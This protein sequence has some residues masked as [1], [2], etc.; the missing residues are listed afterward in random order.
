M[1]PQSEIDLLLGCLRLEDTPQKSA[2]LAA[3]TPADW[4]AVLHQARLHGVLPLLD[5][6]VQRLDPPPPAVPPPVRQEMHQ[7]RLQ[8]AAR[9]MF[10][11]NELGQVLQILQQEAIPVI[12][13]KGLHLAELVYA[14]VALRKIDD[15]DLLIHLKDLQPARDSLIQAGYQP[16]RWVQIDEELRTH[17]HLPPFTSPR[18]TALELH[19]ALA[20]PSSRVN[21]NL[22]E[23]W[24]RAKIA[25]FSG[26]TAR[27]LCLEDLIL[28]LGLHF[29]QHDFHL[30]LR[31]LYDLAVI[32][33]YDVQWEILIER[34]QG[35]KAR[36]CTFL[37]LY[38]ASRILNA[39]VPNFVLEA[40]QPIDFTPQIAEL[41]QSRLLHKAFPPSVHPELAALWGDQP[42]RIRL[43][44]F[45]QVIFPLPEYIADRYNVPYGSRKIYFYY[46]VR[47]VSLLRQYS[48]TV[49][50]I[51]S[52]KPEISEAVRQETLLHD[53]RMKK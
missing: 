18:G 16:Y 44:A 14:D 48:L 10:L 43:A 35:W 52:K 2:R 50:A 15:I 42:L 19:A 47:L 5:W 13:L 7:A 21:I 11:Y 37:P 29:C 25:S 6:Q 22:S 36:K 1:T 24:S 28:H 31:H 9:N 39:P 34:A 3:Y 45:W 8:N 17:L 49:W 4:Q 20:R 51:L 33:E 32:L 12:V 27:I 46:M 53:W 41:A 40:L 30:T 38:L 26:Q 23:V